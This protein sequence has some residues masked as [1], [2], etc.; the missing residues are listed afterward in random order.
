MEQGRNRW[1]KMG[2]WSKDL[3]FPLA[4]FLAAVA[5]TGPPVSSSSSGVSGL[6]G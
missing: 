4:S 1:D 6:K 2:G 3:M 5:G